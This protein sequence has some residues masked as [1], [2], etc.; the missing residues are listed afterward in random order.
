MDHANLRIAVAILA[1]MAGTGA[2]IAQAEDRDRRGLPDFEALDVD[3]SGEIDAADLDTLRANRFAKIDT[4]GD[5]QVDRTEFMEHTA[6]QASERAER[7]FDRLDAD[8]D[9]VL[10]RDVLEGRSGR[11]LGER[12]ISRADADNSGGVSAEEFEAIKERMADGRRGGGRGGKEGR[13]S[14]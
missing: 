7:M 12:M 9:G 6:S 8:G 11:G 2:A 1:I 3:G 13:H 5:G 4:N 14:R 10:S